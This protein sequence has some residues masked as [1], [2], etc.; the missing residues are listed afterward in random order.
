MTQIVP[1]IIPNNPEEIERK[2]SL[3]KG[4]VKK[5][6][7]DF[8]DGKYTWV[9][10]WPFNIEEEVEKNFRFSSTDDV[11]I[12]ADLF[13][14][15]PED[16]IEDFA[17]IGVRSFI[18]HLDSTNYIDKCINNVKSLGL[19]IGLGIKPSMDSKVLDDY[20]DKIDFVQFMGNDKIGYHGVEFDRNVLKK[21]ADFRAA[22][23][24]T[25]IQID[26]GVNPQNAKDLVSAGATSLVSGSSVFSEGNI[27]EN[28]KK[29]QDF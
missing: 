23:P 22:H 4:F 16:F 14:K 15:N 7:L 28:I 10:T 25:P 12:E 24:F 18:I 13:I 26:I 20:V 1:A 17:R 29:L 6:Q 3:V 5:V 19:Q 21:I 8:L 2:I 27:G 11:V 9:V